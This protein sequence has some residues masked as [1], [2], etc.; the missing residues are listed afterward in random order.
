MP[1]HNE[2]GERVCDTHPAKLLLQK[3][4]ENKLHMTAHSTPGKL[5]ASRPEHMLFKRQKFGE[6]IRQ[7]IKLQKY[8]HYLKLKREA[9]RNGKRKVK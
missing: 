3:D 6:R 7:E 4:T 5:Q 1:T 8:L 9:I 2:K